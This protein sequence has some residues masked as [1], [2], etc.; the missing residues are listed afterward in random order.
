MF[1]PP[2]MCHMSH[3]MRHLSGFTCKYFLIFFSQSADAS[4]WR[5]C[6]QRSLPRLVFTIC[7]EL[8]EITRH[9]IKIMC[10]FTTDFK[11]W[12][13]KIFLETLVQNKR[14][15]LWN[16]D[17][18]FKSPDIYNVLNHCYFSTIS[19]PLGLAAL[20]GHERKSG[21]YSTNQWMT[22][23]F[24]VQPLLCPV[25]GFSHYFLKIYFTKEGSFGYEMKEFFPILSMVRSFSL[26]YHLKSFLNTHLII[27]R[28]RDTEKS[29]YILQSKTCLSVWLN[30]TLL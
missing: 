1:N 19:Q 26:G 29:H 24:V 30:L 23:L 11:V 10:F 16:N 3:F 27:A 12:K 25:I 18:I 28:K 4:W 14:G 8:Y 6:Y 15:N 9:Y 21:T 7:K 22:M 20:L 13:E 5:V 2:P 17:A